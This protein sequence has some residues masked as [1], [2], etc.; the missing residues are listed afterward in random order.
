MNRRLI[1]R[2]PAVV[3][4]LTLLTAET[5]IV[6]SSAFAEEHL[7]DL[8]S[9]DI[10]KQTLEQ[11]LGKR[12]KVKLESGQDMEGKV[13][14][15]GAHALQLTELASMELFEATIRLDQVAAV[16]VRVRTK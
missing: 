2:S 9:P 4:L 8:N 6:S 5:S 13:V 16:I 10:I 15:V 7:L 11:Q 14:R 1:A 12:V 3:L